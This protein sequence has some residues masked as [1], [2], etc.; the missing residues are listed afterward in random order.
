[1]GRGFGAR[2]ALAQVRE[3]RLAIDQ[4]ED[5]RG[6]CRLD[7]RSRMPTPPAGHAGGPGA[8]SGLSTGRPILV[9]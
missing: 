5:Q 3:I 1:M 4:L 8:L 2:D 7:G 6:S 9:R